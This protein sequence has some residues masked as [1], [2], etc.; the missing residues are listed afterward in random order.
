[1]VKTFNLEGTHLVRL[2]TAN[3]ELYGSI[4]SNNR[5]RSFCYIKQLYEKRLRYFCAEF[6]GGSFKPNPVL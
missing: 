4:C 2:V 1:M 6:Q 5:R 3:F